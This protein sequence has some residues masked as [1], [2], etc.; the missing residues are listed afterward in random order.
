MEFDELVEAKHDT[1]MRSLPPREETKNWRDYEL[2]CEQFWGTWANQLDTVPICDKANWMLEQGKYCFIMGHD[3][4]QCT[5]LIKHFPFA[6]VIK[7]VN[8]RS[9]NLLSRKLKTDWNTRIHTDFLKSFNP[10]GCLHFDIGS[11]FNKQDFFKNI[12]C[13][14][15]SIGIEDRSLDAR[16]DEYYQK[17]CNLY[18]GLV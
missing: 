17:Y 4:D 14:L 8:D 3:I 16:V 15:A 12:D 5:A 13:L 1:I 10:P 7:L 18:Q 9:V 2:G 6:T 11:L